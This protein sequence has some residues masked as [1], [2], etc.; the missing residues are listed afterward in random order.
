MVEDTFKKNKV[1]FSVLI[2]LF[3]SLLYKKWKIFRTKY[4]H[5][6]SVKW[7][8]LK[9]FKTIFLSG[10]TYCRSIFPFFAPENI[11]KLLAFK[12]V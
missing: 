11:S 7:N 5:F 1:I 12:G 2:G 4:T 3:V 10:L 8:R 9:R 6:K